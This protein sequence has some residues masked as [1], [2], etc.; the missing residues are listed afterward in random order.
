MRVGH[1]QNIGF[2]VPTECW[3]GER[4]WDESSDARSS[5]DG[6]CEHPCRALA[7]LS[8]GDHHHILD[9]EPSK[10]CSDV[11]NPLIG[12]RDVDEVQPVT[13]HGFD[14]SRHVSTL[15]V[16]P[17]VHGAGLVGHARNEERGFCRHLFVSD[18]APP[19]LSS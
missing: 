17:D 3:V 9:G 14:E 15:L 12:L 10:E 16:R 18:V 1:E 4:S 13:S 11:P 19:T 5:S 7:I 2:E 8:C 6:L